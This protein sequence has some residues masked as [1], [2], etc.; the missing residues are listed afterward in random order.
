MSARQL[1]LANL[2]SRRFDEFDSDGSSADDD[3]D[4]SDASDDIVVG[5]NDDSSLADHLLKVTPPRNA[6]SETRS[7]FRDKSHSSQICV[8][9]AETESKSKP[10]L[11]EAERKPTIAVIPQVPSSPLMRRAESFRRKASDRQ[12]N[13]VDKTHPNK[14]TRHVRSFSHDINARRTVHRKSLS[15]SSSFTEMNDELTA[16]TSTISVA[17]INAALSMTIPNKNNTIQT[18][19]EHLPRCP[20]TGGS[21]AMVATS[22]S[23]TMRSDLDDTSTEA[24]EAITSFSGSLSLSNSKSF[25]SSTSKSSASK[26]L[27]RLKRLSIGGIKRNNN[28]YDTKEVII[29]GYEMQVDMSRSDISEKSSERSLVMKSRGRDVDRLNKFT[30]TNS[31]IFEQTLIKPG[32]MSLKELKS[33]RYGGNDSVTSERE[34]LPGGVKSSTSFS[35]SAE[36]LSPSMTFQPSPSATMGNKS[37]SSVVSRTELRRSRSVSRNSNVTLKSS[38]SARASST[39]RMAPNS[40]P[41]STLNST[42]A[43]PNVLDRRAKTM[44]TPPRTNALS[45]IPSAPL[46]PLMKSSHKYHRNG[47]SQ[48]PHIGPRQ[49]SRS[50]ALQNACTRG[51]LIG[52]ELSPKPES[53]FQVLKP[54]KLASLSISVLNKAVLPIQSLARSYIAKLT[55]NDR[56]KNIVVLQSLIR[57]WLCLRY[58]QSASTIALTF[59]AAYRGMVTR[60][61]LDFRHYCASRIQATFRGYVG[62]FFATRVLNV[63]LNPIESHS[64]ISCSSIRLNELHRNSQEH[65]S[66]P[67]PTAYDLPEEQISGYR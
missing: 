51:S 13:K 11:T 25:E 44:M 16:V 12:E 3:D 52:Q 1:F 6:E 19:R 41:K 8:N 65:Y 39:P 49:R 59:Q 20:T 14:P 2:A 35:F 29:G 60:D 47:L 7:L 43:P 50:P 62:K 27:E 9:N 21:I 56:R 42:P 54:S 30:E 55:I 48:S 28:V 15:T 33:R 31:P 17:S 32:R 36:K 34:R 18:R 64:K 10:T 22:K 40:P 67:K 38:S 58:Y 23:F 63:I 66:H 37:N 53:I 45:N 5:V 46:S 24:T 4:D 57:R 26:E 61:Q